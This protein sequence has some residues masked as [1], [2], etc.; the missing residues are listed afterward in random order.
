MEYAG[1]AG[2]FPCPEDGDAVSAGA[3]HVP[4][5]CHQVVEH[6]HLPYWEAHPNSDSVPNCLI[7]YLS[8]ISCVPESARPD[9]KEDPDAGF[10]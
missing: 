6:L 7:R 4:G 9:E 8:L 3:A 2:P 1:G 5:F 10:G